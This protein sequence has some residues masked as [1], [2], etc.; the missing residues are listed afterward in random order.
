MLDN[1]NKFFIFK[2]LLATPINVLPLHLKQT[3][4]AHNLKVKVTG[5]NPGYLLKYFLLYRKM[6]PVKI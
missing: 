6:E 3:F 5:L 4:S 1:V 2:S